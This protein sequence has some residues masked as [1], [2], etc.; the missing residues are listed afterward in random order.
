MRRARS[1]A[2]GQYFCLI[3]VARGPRISFIGKSWW[4]QQAMAGNQSNDETSMDWRSQSAAIF[5]YWAYLTVRDQ[6]ISGRV[7]VAEP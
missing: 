6:L 1:I 5:L 7:H 3:S 2:S 4:S